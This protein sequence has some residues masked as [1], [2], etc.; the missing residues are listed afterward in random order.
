MSF[1]DSP[2]EALKRCTNE[3]KSK[4]EIEAKLRANSFPLYTCEQ[5]FWSPD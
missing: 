5:H 2:L 3:K 1:L 4:P